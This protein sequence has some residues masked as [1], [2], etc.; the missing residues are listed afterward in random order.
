MSAY[1]ANME[2]ARIIGSGKRRGREPRPAARAAG[3]GPGAY[4][5]S[6]TLKRYPNP[7]TSAVQA[8]LSQ[9][10]HCD[11]K[12][13]AAALGIHPR[14]IRRILRRLDLTHLLGGTET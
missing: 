2:G 3:R 12:R 5:P 6:T 1:A 10:C 9:D 13:A 4:R 14:T 7:A 11:Y 8:P